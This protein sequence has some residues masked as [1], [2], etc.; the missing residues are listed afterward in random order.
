MHLDMKKSLSKRFWSL[1]I[2]LGKRKDSQVLSSQKWD[3]VIDPYLFIRSSESRPF[4][5]FW[6][7]F[8]VSTMNLK[9]TLNFDRLL[10]KVDHMVADPNP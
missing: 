8:Q 4:R 2:L 1:I 7:Y 10:F 5:F 9:L 3:H 6:K